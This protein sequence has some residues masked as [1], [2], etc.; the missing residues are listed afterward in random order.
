ME[1]QKTDM[2]LRLEDEAE[3]QRPWQKPLRAGETEKRE[4]DLLRFMK[5]VK[6]VSS[7]CW[8]WQGY[9][10]QPP[11]L[12]YGIFYCGNPKKAHRWLYTQIY[13]DLPRNV[14]VCHRCDNPKCVNPR[15]LFTGTHQENM[16]DCVRK[17]RRPGHKPR[18]LRPN[19]KL[20]M[21]Q[22]DTIRK[23]F[24]PGMA[25][26]LAREYGVFTSTVMG[27]VR[28]KLYGPRGT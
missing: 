1:T 23:V 27:I 28:G 14:F 11:T 6:R 21:E 22:A 17:G 18:Q 7:G 9:L 4:A 16:D 19:A 10:S 8:E 12:G 26:I 5:K 3:W 15:H 24:K 2:L 25:P 13:G 20:T